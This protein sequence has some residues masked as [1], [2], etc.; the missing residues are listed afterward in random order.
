MA[1]LGQDP[2]FGG[3]G[4]A[5]SAAFLDGA[6][7]LGRDP[8]FL[9]EPHPGLNRQ[10]LPS[11]VEALYQLR[12][13]R[14][15]E[16]PARAARSLWVVAT[17]AANGGAA[18]RSQRTYDCWVAT[19]IDAEWSGRSPGMARAHRTA[20]A[21]S[22]P[23]LRHVE[24]SVLRGARR[25]FATSEATQNLLVQ[26][27]GLGAER[28]S[29]LRVP[30]D[31]DA[32][33]P[34]ED[35]CWLERAGSQPIIGFVG[36]ADDPRKNVQVLVESFREVRARFPHARLRLIGKPPREPLEPG[37][38]VT[39]YVQDVPPVLR[40]CSLFVLPSLQ[41]GFGIAAAEALAAGVPVVSTPSGGPESLIRASG[42]GAVTA[43]FEASEI[44]DACIMFLG[45]SSAL[46][47]ARHRGRAYVAAHYSKGAFLNDLGAAL[48]KPETGL[49][50]LQP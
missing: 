29:I 15:L 30:V 20:A 26:S 47:A 48:E 36:R 31:S 32:F 23:V 9:Y 21:L 6:R 19:T 28:I 10:S 35:D 11:R 37:V 16:A 8:T 45:D 7:E 5:L 18:P 24:K 40:E 39:G 25:V 38:E 4:Q 2:R 50:T 49:A 27:V 46:L 43:T 13:A 17:M 33:A 44:A 34:E 14:R 41:E 1:V 22:L 3:G 42:G 12:T